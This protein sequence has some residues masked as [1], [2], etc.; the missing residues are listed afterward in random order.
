MSEDSQDYRFYA[1]NPVKLKFEVTD[2]DAS[3]ETALD[4]SSFTAKWAI[5]RISAK[6]GE[7]LTSPIVEKKQ[8][9]GGITVTDAANGKLEVDLDPADTQGLSGEFHH[10][11][12]VFDGQ[13]NGVVVAV[14]TLTI[15]K[16]VENT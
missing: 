3:P 10:E 11:L 16:N 2:K 5:S 15:D 1:N 13:G 7:Y 8:S 9:S 14:G 4:L 6:T 12:E